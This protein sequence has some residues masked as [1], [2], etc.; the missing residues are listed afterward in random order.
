MKLLLNMKGTLNF[1]FINSGLEALIY[2]TRA[3]HKLCA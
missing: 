3:H 2:T 1:C